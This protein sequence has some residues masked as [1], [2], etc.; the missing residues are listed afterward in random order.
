MDVKSSTERRVQG[1]AD[2]LPSRM[3]REIRGL[4]QKEGQLHKDH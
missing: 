3:Q 1:L 4:E 2:E